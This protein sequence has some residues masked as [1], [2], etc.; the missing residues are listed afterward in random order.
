[1]AR[2]HPVT[3]VGQLLE[4]LSEPIKSGALKPGD[5]LPSISQMADEFGV[6]RIVIRE[7]LKSLEAK[8]VVELKNGKRARVRSVTNEPLIDYFHHAVH[9]E[10]SSI[11]DF[12]EIR[13]AL[14]IQAAGLAAQRR[15]AAEVVTMEATLRAMTETISQ[16]E[17]FGNHDAELHL[18]I[19]RATHNEMMFRILSSIRDVITEVSREGLSR[20][21]NS[22]QLVSVR[23]LHERIVACIA[24]RDPAGAR[25]AMTDHFDE[26]VMSIGHT[27]KT[28]GGKRGD[29]HDDAT[30]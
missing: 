15:T 9:V 25:Q 20:R 22:R 5:E 29:G 7:A 1:L 14:E 30:G 18:S 26:T 12:M 24:A 23:L 10:I 28:A 27:E 6:S 19:A 11:A 16:I 13:Q 17:L 4:R 8:G 3:L 2:I 21:F